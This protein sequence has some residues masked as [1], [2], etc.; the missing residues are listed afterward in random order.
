MRQ[1]SLQTHKSNTNLLCEFT[2]ISDYVEAHYLLLPTRSGFHRHHS[3]ETAIIKV[4]NEIVLTLDFGFI[5]PT[6]PL[7]SNSPLI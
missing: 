3:T 2:I 1:N 5:R 7:L 4:Y 6:T